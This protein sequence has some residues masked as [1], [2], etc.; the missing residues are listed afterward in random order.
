MQR[1]YCPECDSANPEGAVVCSLCGH[2]LSEP[3]APP[4]IVETLI[5]PRVVLASESREPPLLKCPGGAKRR[6]RWTWNFV[7]VFLG[8]AI[9]TGILLSVPEP[10]AQ[11]AMVFIIVAL[12]TFVSFVMVPGAV[13]HDR[14]HHNE[15]AIWVVSLLFGWSFLGWGI[16]LV[17]AFSNPPFTLEKGA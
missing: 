9:V 16:A 2:K 3:P 4:L 1:I 6:Y 10:S 7:V 11:T 5:D 12:V 8:A 14:G 15:N 17:W 13:A